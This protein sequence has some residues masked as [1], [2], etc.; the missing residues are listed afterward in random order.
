VCAAG[1]A[2]AIGKLVAEALS[3]GWNVQVIA[4]PAAATWLDSQ[5]LHVQTNSPVRSVHEPNKERSPKPDAVIVAP[6]SF[7][8]IAKLSL[9]ISD[10][11]ALDFLHPKINKNKEPPIVILP[12]TNTGYTGRLVFQDHVQR[13]RAEGVSVLLGEGGFVPHAPGTGDLANFPW[14]AALDEVERLL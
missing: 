3:R 9:G 2:A 8:T 6:A 13:L 7:N 11:Y 12:F 1:P 4:T 5:A 10:N 14:N